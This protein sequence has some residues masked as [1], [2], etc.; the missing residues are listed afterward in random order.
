M[1]PPGLQTASVDA[2]LDL[3]GCRSTDEQRHLA[4]LAGDLG[5]RH[6]RFEPK[7]HGG[8]PQVGQVRRAVSAARTARSW[9]GTVRFGPARSTRYG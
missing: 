8:V 1:F 9:V 7:R 2:Q 3:V 5:S 4:S 6:S